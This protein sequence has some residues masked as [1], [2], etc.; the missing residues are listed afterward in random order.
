MLFLTFPN[1]AQQFIERSVVFA[2]ER[3]SP[4]DILIQLVQ[5]NPARKV[6]YTE[7]NKVWWGIERQNLKSKKEF[8]PPRPSLLRLAVDIL[9]RVVEPISKTLIY[10]LD[11]QVFLN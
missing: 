6:I 1:T 11:R 10:L 2:G 9:Q 4:L 7:R 8:V 3:L 5:M